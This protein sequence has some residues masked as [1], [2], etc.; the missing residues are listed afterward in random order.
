MTKTLTV[1]RAS[2]GTGKTFTLAA[3]YVALLMQGASFRSILAVT[4]TNKA[5]QEMKERILSYLFAI[6]KGEA[7]DFLD[8]VKSIIR[9]Q[10]PAD[11]CNDQILRTRAEECFH[12]ILADYDNMKVVTIDSFLQVLLS[13]MAHQL[14]WP[15]GYAIDLDQEHAISTAV[16]QLLTTHIEEQPGLKEIIISYINRQL[17]D[18]KSWDV[19]GKV[20][21]IAQE[22]FKEAVQKDADDIV[23]DPDL[24]KQFLNDSNW[25]KSPAAVEINRLIGTI[26]AHAN[27]VYEATGGKFYKGMVERAKKI[28]LGKAG[29]GDF[30]GLSQREQDRLAKPA[31]RAEVGS[32]VVEALSGLHEILA[33]DQMQQHYACWKLTT[34]HLEDMQLMSFVKHQIEENQRENNSILLSQ[35]APIL[36]EALKPGDADFILEKA[37]I[38]YKHIMIDE[39]QDT[40]SMQWENFLELIKEILAG[41]GTTL[42]V[43]DIKQSIYRWRNGDW[44]IMK[45][46]DTQ[47]PELGHYFEPKQLAKNFR[48]RENIVRFALE[49]MQALTRLSQEPT[50]A[51]H[52]LHELYEEGYSPEHLTDFYN[53]KKNGGLVRYRVYPYKSRGN[54]QSEVDAE[55]CLKH[56]VA[57]KAILKDMFEQI[58]HLLEMGESPENIMILIRGRSDVKDIIRTYN[59]MKLLYNNLQGHKPVSVDSYQ[60]DASV[61]VNVI[62][63]ALRLIAQGDTMG[64]KYIQMALGESKREELCQL[65]STLPLSSL[66]EEVIKIC[67]MKNGQFCGTDLAYVNCMKDKVNDFI[68]SY[69]SSVNDFL[70][71]WDDSMHANA[72]P[73]ADMG[74]IK[75]MTIHSSK[76]LESKTLF[77]PFCSWPMEDDGKKGGKLWCRSR[78]TLSN[79]N[80]MK[81]VPISNK[82]DMLLAGYETEYQQEHLNERVDNMNLLYV[83]LTRAGNNLFLYSDL[84]YDSKEPGAGDTIGHLLV[85]SRNMTQ[86]MQTAWDEYSCPIDP[87]E[88]PDQVIP[89]FIEYQNG[90]IVIAKSE[91]ATESNEKP[92]SFDTA[93]TIPVTYYS[94]NQ[95][96]EFRQ[97]QESRLYSQTQGKDMAEVDNQGFGNLCHNILSEIATPADMPLV[98]Q[99]YQNNGLITSNELMQK[100]K[101]TI[102]DVWENTQMAEWFSDKW[103]LMREST[104]VLPERLQQ[105]FEAENENHKKPE[106][107]RPDRIMINNEKKQAVVLDYKFGV[108]I[109]A[110]YYTQ[111]KQYMTLMQELGYTNVTGYIWAAQDKQLLTVQ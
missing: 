66:I 73:T 51:E 53:T 2:A 67:L 64:E 82:S 7:T 37:G 62:I 104:I 22:L 71:Y 56:T 55:R 36:H 52:M 97:S 68:G 18:E 8:T 90:T 103:T 102:N 48:S 81:L 109:K 20:I 4:F 32:E 86:P 5:T 76:G 59:E 29:S 75:M 61:S 42:I 47:H 98:L 26:E 13:G 27:V 21:D 3:Y 74:N 95:H 87:E 99:R 108:Q 39:F 70:T 88:A 14:G 45:S 46:L 11:P 69:G 72:V 44:K 80:N 111:V 94:D 34:E 107:L 93:S 65:S 25:V 100:V 23:F 60:L 10:N 85:R 38:R 58:S 79:G 49:T 50:D 12:A 84:Q 15:A 63:S 28:V 40:S 83:A 89:L 57:R 24:I 92:F 35:T 1:C 78:L 43:G 33:D 9:K 30:K 110:A 91:T 31:Y 19:R 105:Q 6:S 54:K 16:D 96:I 17:A 77:I 41:G 106:E 101:Q